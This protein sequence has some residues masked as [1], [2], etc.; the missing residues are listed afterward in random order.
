MTG[1][2]TI[3]VYKTELKLQKIREAEKAEA[4]RKQEADRPAGGQGEGSIRA[5]K[6]GGEG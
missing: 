6:A 2:A 1:K 5:E 4:A 3:E